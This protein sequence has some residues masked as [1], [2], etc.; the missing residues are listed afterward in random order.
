MSI[1]RKQIKKSFLILCEGKDAE[2][3][4]IYYLGND[5]LAHDPRFSN[6][7]QVFDFGGNTDLC[8]FLLNL[9]NMDGFDRV[10]SLAIIRDAEKDYDKACREVRSAFKHCDFIS[11]Q[12]C[13]TWET[14]I[15]GIKIGF[16]LFPLNNGAGTLEDLCLSI[17]SEENSKDILSSIKTFLSEM[18]ASYGRV[19]H[20]KHKNVL[21]T[22]L[23]ASDKY[24]T[25]P[26][27]IASK[28]GAFDWA[29]KELEPLLRFIKEGF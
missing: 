1:E 17:L 28:S 5:K 18:E 29:S 2:Q 26:I 12:Q 4:L 27:G 3:F 16:I 25:M 15:S 11:P 23:S 10:S 22:Y 13:G 6:D 19:Y 24:V 8:S 14:D 20:R 9:K 21:H 7:I